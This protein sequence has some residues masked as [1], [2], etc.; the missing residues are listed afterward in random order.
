LLGEPTPGAIA[1]L[2][3][4]WLFALRNLLRP[5]PTATIW[6]SSSTPS[7]RASSSLCLIV[8]YRAPITR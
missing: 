5:K 8:D 3:A 1:R 2:H 6:N 4:A 7:V